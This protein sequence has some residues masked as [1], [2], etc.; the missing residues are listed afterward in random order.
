MTA[1]REAARRRCPRS[2]ASAA[3]SSALGAKARAARREGPRGAP[4]APSAWPVRSRPPAGHLERSVAG[5]G[6]P[7]PGAGVSRGAG[8]PGAPAPPRPE[9]G[10]RGRGGGARAPCWQARSWR[11]EA[12]TLGV[13][14]RVPRGAREAPPGD[15]R[16][17]DGEKKGGEKWA[18]GRR[19]RPGLK[20]MPTA[21]RDQDT[22]W[23]RVSGAPDGTL[24]VPGRY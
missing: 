2:G 18:G 4:A 16:R 20:A 3:A 14:P 6:S 10:S 12:A 17:T 19:E 23:T 13:H 21:W 8:V 7:P 22:R 1:G 24:Q 5:A 15:E 11:R 9:S